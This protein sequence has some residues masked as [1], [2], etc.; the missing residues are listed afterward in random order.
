MMERG[1]R[2]EYSLLRSDLPVRDAVIIGY[3]AAR[4]Q[5]ELFKDLARLAKGEILAPAQAA[6][7]IADD[8][9]VPARAAGRID[10]FPDMDD[11]SL[12]VCRHSFFLLLQAAGEDHIRVCR[13]FGKEEIN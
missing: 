6:R 4:R 5:P 7:Q 8:F 3:A 1:A 2:R 9:G 11:A 12:D 13:G 10:G